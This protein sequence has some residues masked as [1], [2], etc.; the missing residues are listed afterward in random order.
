VTGNGLIDFIKKRQ[1]S[2]FP[3][4]R[5]LIGWSVQRAN[6]WQAPLLPMY[7]AAVFHS[8]TA[9]G[10]IDMAAKG[11]LPEDHGEKIKPEQKPN[12]FRMGD[13]V[14]L[15][16]GTFTNGTVTGILAGAVFVAWNNISGEPQW[17]NHDLVLHDAAAA[18]E[19]QL[20][21]RRGRDA[22][23]ATPGVAGNQEDIVG[24]LLLQVDN[25]DA[26]QLERFDR[27]YMKR[28]RPLTKT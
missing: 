7:G 22:P 20:A 23:A 13:H 21:A 5:A 24:D 18:R 9:Q 15:R 11:H 17:Y 16:D 12:P 2:S 1:I 8:E 19:A 3:Q 4:N 26:R 28:Y 10:T 14:R 27:D 6:S 25:L